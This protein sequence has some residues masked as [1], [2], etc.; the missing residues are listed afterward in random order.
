MEVF[1][2]VTGNRE[3]KISLILYKLEFC[4][5]VESKVLYTKLVGIMSST[6]FYYSIIY[7]L[8]LVCLSFSELQMKHPK[9]TTEAESILQLFLGICLNLCH[10]KNSNSCGI[11]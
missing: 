7:I 6:S 5:Q 2:N 8:L 4:Y 9:Y 1:S 3:D 11:F 10:I